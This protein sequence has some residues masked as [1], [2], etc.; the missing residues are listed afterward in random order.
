MVG[1]SS[2]NGVEA[3]QAGSFTIT[4]S[5][6]LSSPLVVT[7]T[8][9][10]S[11]TEGADFHPVPH[12]VTIPA[13]QSSI[14]IS[15]LNFDNGIDDGDDS[16]SLTLAASPSY[17]L[18][19]L[20]TQT[21]TIHE[22]IPGVPPTIF[23]PTNEVPPTV[24]PEVPPTVPP[25]VPPIPPVPPVPPPPPPP[26]SIGDTV[27]NDANGDGLQNY[28]ET[29]RPDVVVSL[30]NASGTTMITTT[31]TDNNGHY[32][33]ANLNTQNQYEVKFTNPNIASNVF[34]TPS[35]FGPIALEP[36]QNNT[37]I[38]AGLASTGQSVY[39]RVWEDD[40]KNGIQEPGEPG[41]NRVG[42]FL[43][44]ENHVM[45]TGVLT[46][47]DGSYFFAN[48]PDGK[49]VV[50]FAKEHIE[51]FDRFSPANQGS[52]DDIDSDVTFADSFAGYTTQFQ[53]SAQTKNKNDAGVVPN[54]D[55][56][57]TITDKSVVEA[58]KLKVAKWN[59]AFETIADPQ[60]PFLTKSK[61]K[62]QLPARI[63]TSLIVTTI[64]SMSG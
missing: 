21:L 51:F 44:G 35:T 38:D 47:A 62:D 50:E 59:D 20:P 19:S 6:D 53:V 64:D 1:I 9:S 41:I 16:L 3:S 5:G 30:F 22:P 48:V 33:F 2:T 37:G 34:T 27:W 23:P 43:Y 49:Y 55:I 54:D 11:A 14:T 31:M 17:T 4:R 45:Y 61:S 15:I 26:G 10:G 7:F 58:A 42:V 32:S 24:P 29:G 12:T 40:N 63:T 13:G 60:I 25:E 8:L 52:N 18:F 46:N 28:A 39:G 57:I 36:G 56:K